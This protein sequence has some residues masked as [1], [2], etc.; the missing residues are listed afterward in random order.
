ME[1]ARREGILHNDV[2]ALDRLLADSYLETLG[3]GRLVKKADV[4]A[5]NRSS[6]R[7]VESYGET[8]VLV[9]VYGDTAVVTGLYEVKD[10]GLGN[11][12]AR[13]VKGRFTHVWT[14][15]DG[16]WQLVERATNGGTTTQ[17]VQVWQE[18]RAVAQVQK[19]DLDHRTIDLLMNGQKRSVHVANDVRVI[20]TNGQS[21]AAG[22]AAQE[23]APGTTVRVTAI[24][25]PSIAVSTVIELRITP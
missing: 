25:D 4:L 18:L 1:N 20:G 13:Q 19:V 9:R 15:L 22:L 6:D 12:G 7:Q 24:P 10:G 5:V 14:T 23:L 3:D 16:R 2:A 17:Q 11:A 8:D 21:L